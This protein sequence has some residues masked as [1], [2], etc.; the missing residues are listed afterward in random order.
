[1]PPPAAPA[2][3]PTPRAPQ[4]ISPAWLTYALRAGGALR[5]GAVTD[6]RATAIGEG[7][8]FLSRVLRVALTYAGGGAGAPASVVVKLEPDAGA[9]HV[10]G[11]ELHAFARE[12]RFYREVAA[13]APVR[14]PRLYYADAG[15]PSAALVLEDLSFATPGDQVA[16][17]HAAQVH[18]TLRLIGGLQAGFWDNAALAALDWM[19]SSNRIGADFDARWPSLA[20]HFGA[21]IGADGLA[22]GER[23]R[24][25]CDWLEAAIARRP[26]TIVHSDLRADNLLF[27]PPDSADA[28]LIVDWQLAIRS[29]GAFD[30]ARLMGGSELPAERRGHQREALATWHD[31]LRAGGVRDYAFADAQRDLRLGA[32]AVLTWPA[33]FHTGVLGSRDRGWTLV[34]TICRRVFASAVEL[35]AG[36]VLE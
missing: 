11:D 29:L 35:D 9:F 22:L 31:A 6:C 7:V 34:E 14:L 3:P 15:P 10:L 30:V 26:R 27:G 18:A 36:A 28:V 24:G 5:D 1:M 23:L 2:A 21:Q 12:I 19:P 25:R 20:Q 13:V 32:L 4:E 17:M 8:G 16:G 33:H